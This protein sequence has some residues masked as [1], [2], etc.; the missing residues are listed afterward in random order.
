MEQTENL[1]GGGTCPP[2]SYAYVHYPEF[3]KCWEI[4]HM[5]KEWIPGPF[6]RF[7]EQASF[8]GNK[9]VDE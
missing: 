9:W 1:G 2:G 3:P 4:K 6:L 7:F 5:C 8:Y